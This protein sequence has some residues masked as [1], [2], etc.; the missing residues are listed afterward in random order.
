MEYRFLNSD[1][2]C[3]DI[4]IKA[5]EGMT[6]EA[7]TTPA[8]IDVEA[9]GLGRNSYPVEIGGVTSEGG[10]WCYIIRPESD[11]QHWDAS[12][13]KL[14]KI[15]RQ[16][17]IDRGLPAREVALELNRRLAGMTVYSDGWGNDLSWLSLLFEV[18]EVSQHFRLESI[19]HLLTPEHLAQWH[20][21]KQ[22][23]EGECNFTRH[24]A[25]GDAQILQQTYN[26]VVYGQPLSSHIESYLKMAKFG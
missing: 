6:M 24:R 10:P 13:E 18:A 7:N 14:H 22:Q 25:S 21:V 1:L 2:Y 26:R 8:F 5:A 3:R 23:V 9:S 4:L 11:W 15:S 12:A 17:L 16:T 19:A 20:A